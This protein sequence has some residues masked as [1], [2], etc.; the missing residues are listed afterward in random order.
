MRMENGALSTNSLKT[1]DRTPLITKLILALVFLLGLLVIFLGYR[2]I[3]EYNASGFSSET[4]YSAIHALAGDV[5]AAWTQKLSPQ[6]EALSAEKRD[7]L[8]EAARQLL[9]SAWEG[10]KAGGQ[11]DAEAL[12]AAEKDDT[13]LLYRLLYTTY[14]VN[15]PKVS[16]ANKKEVAALNAADMAAFREELL[17][18]LTDEAAVLPA[19]AEGA[20]G[21]L[22]GTEKQAMLM[23]LWFVSNDSAASTEQ[24]NTLKKSVRDKE[25]QLTAFRMAAKGEVSWLWQL[26]VSNSRTARF[27]HCKR[28]FGEV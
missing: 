17:T 18:C 15:G 13:G 4:A 2:G 11:K 8:D 14:L 19:A 26:V 22:E 23:Q 5:N 27:Y 20:A 9:L 25:L 24:V 6:R 28:C 7:A 10:Q 16:T 21:K 12:L 3:Q 1:R